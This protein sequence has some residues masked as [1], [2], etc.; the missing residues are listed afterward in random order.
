MRLFPTKQNESFKKH[1]YSVEEFI[2]PGIKFG[3]QVA[4]IHS[5]LEKKEESQDYEL[6]SK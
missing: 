4:K 3:H 5:E 2:L 6:L 1:F